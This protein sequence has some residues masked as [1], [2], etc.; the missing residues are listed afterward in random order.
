MARSSRPTSVVTF[1]AKPVAR[2]ITEV[3]KDRPVE[4]EETLDFDW[5]D[6]VQEVGEPLGVA[7]DSDKWKPRNGDGRRESEVYKHIRES[8]NRIYVEPGLLQP[9]TGFDFEPIGPRLSLK[10][11]SR[12][13]EII[14]PDSF[15]VLGRFV[16]CNVVLHT[17]GTDE[18]PRRATSGDKGVVTFSV[19]HGMLGASKMRRDGRLQPFLFVYR[20]D[21]GVYFII[22][23]DELDIERDGIVG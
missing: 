5:P 20:P 21:F 23:G 10:E 14:M 6:V 11:A 7:Y 16:E 18:A 3:F 12:H 2:I 19:K 8:R 15:A 4:T 13:G 22:T 9:D 17:S 1:D